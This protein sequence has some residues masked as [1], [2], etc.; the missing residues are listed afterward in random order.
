MTRASSN[1]GTSSSSSAGRTVGVSEAGDHPLHLMQLAR[2]L[3]GV[4]ALGRPLLPPRELPKKTGGSSS[5]G[6][7]SSSS[8]GDSIMPAGGSS[9][10]ISSSLSAGSIK[11]STGSTSS[12]QTSFSSAESTKKSTA[13]SGAKQ[14]ALPPYSG[15][16]SASSTGSAFGAVTRKRDIF[17][18]WKPE[19]Y[20]IIICDQ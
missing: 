9:R 19:K 4:L 15:Q 12:G 8:C 14:S 11:M 2:C 13:I 1:T 6:Q 7:T 16:N 10:G 20:S 17:I 18:Y 3:W 5:A